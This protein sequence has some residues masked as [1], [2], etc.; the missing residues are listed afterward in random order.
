MADLDPRDVGDGVEWPGGPLE[1]DAQVP[2]AGLPRR[3]ETGDREQYRDGADFLV[4]NPELLRIGTELVAL[5]IPI[6]QTLNE[7]EALK[8]QAGAIAGRFVELFE[9][10]VWDPFVEAGMPG[11]RLTEVTDTL[12]RLRPLA[13]RGVAATLGMAMDEAVASATVSHLSPLVERAPA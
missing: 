12:R 7:F 5:G 6:E 1:G 9:R 13:A 11:E 2:R 8:T 3:G 10:F 4:P